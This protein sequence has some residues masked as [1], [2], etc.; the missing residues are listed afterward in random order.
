VPVSQHTCILQYVPQSPSCS[1]LYQGL[2]TS[3]SPACMPGLAS[4]REQSEGLIIPMQLTLQLQG[5]LWDS[6]LWVCTETQRASLFNP[7]NCKDIGQCSLREVRHVGKT[8]LEGKTNFVSSYQNCCREC[9]QQSNSQDIH[10][11]LEEVFV[12]VLVSRTVPVFF[13]RYFPCK[14]GM[15]QD[16]NERNQTS[17]SHALA[18]YCNN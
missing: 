9:K 3:T 5:A 14:I 11:L 16:S 13:P 18:E 10:Q 1:C 6:S 17:L 15:L 12:V 7:V 8:G 2:L 4:R